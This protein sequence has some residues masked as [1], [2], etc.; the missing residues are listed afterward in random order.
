[1]EEFKTEVGQVT[2]DGLK[3]EIMSLPKETLADLVD[4]WMRNYWTCQ[5]NWMV[6][7]EK[8]FGF[9]NA[10][11]LDAEVFEAAARVQAYRLKKILNLG[12]DVQALAAVIKWTALQ[13]VGAG[14][15]WDVVEISDRTL[16]VK[17]TK[18]PMGTYRTKENLPLL[19][20]KSVSPPLYLAAARVINEKFS[21]NCRQAPPDPREPGV[22]CEW[23]FVLEA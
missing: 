8:Y 22:M 13:W 15:E 1:M 14:F 18:C 17:V 2:W 6:A 7:V 12:D 11:K 23:E 9:E 3:Q 4:M 5:S 19:P 16:V 20:C 21:L 10:G